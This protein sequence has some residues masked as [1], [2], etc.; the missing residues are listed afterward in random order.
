MC[1]ITGFWLNAA[2]A[3]DRARAALGDMS[4]SIAHRG[5]DDSDHYFDA[6]AGLGLAHRR[7]SIVDLSPEGRQPMVS[8]SGRYVIVF[9]GEV[10]N[11]RE[12]RAQLDANLVPL[13]FR[14][15]SD[16]E[17]M[18]AAIEAWGLD[19]A[20]A[21]FVGMFAFALWDRREHSLTLVRDRLGVKPLFY[22]PLARGFVFGSEL[23]AILAFPGF[24]RRLDDA[25]LYEFLLRGHVPAPRAIYEG[26]YK[27]P[28]G[29]TLRLSGPASPPVVERY[30]DAQQLGRAAVTQ[31]APPEESALLEEVD[32]LLRSAVR[33]RM[34]A[35]VPLGAFLSGGIDSSLVVALMQTQSTQPVRTFSIGSERA[36][37]DEG[38]AAARVAAHLG[39]AHTP[40][41]VTAADAQGVVPS[42][43]ALF[44]EPFADSSQIPTL[45]V[46]RLARAEVTVALTGDG[47]DES[48]GGYNRHSW[49]PRAWRVLR[50]LP[51]STRRRLSRGL[52]AIP[53]GGY[54]A[55]ARLVPSAIRPRLAGNKAHKL[56]GVMGSRSSA[57]LYRALCAHW[58]RP[59]DVLSRPVRAE[60]AF[61]TVD[62][63]DLA[64]D[65]M[66]LDTITYLPDDVLTKVDRATMAVA[67]EARSPLLDHRVV[68]LASRLPR[69]LKIRRGVGKWA[70]RE[71]LYRY[72]PRAL[73]DRPK[74][75]FAV[76]VG[77]WLRGPLKE[78]A[79]DLLLGDARRGAP[80]FQ[81]AAVRRTWEEHL[82]GRQDHTAKLWALLMFRAWLTGPHGTSQ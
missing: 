69:S 67:L 46:S 68:E 32:A 8:A 66:L 37:Y 65:M 12:L 21:R 60:S 58:L 56:L 40:F 64:Q 70:L 50:R 72:V 20:V 51:A 49:G 24:E 5:P 79:S 18:L 19:A 3:A 82:S 27:V 62:T 28:P 33:L 36:E 54:D 14:G 31:V 76:P 78:W 61:P 53:P 48:F 47:G 13:R 1:G 42:L 80:Y 2:W 4:T 52:G 17:V 6:A 16:T 15:E 45:L 77:A 81:P 10:Y 35:D 43:G 73:V 74:M 59:E 23:S 7:L 55:L 11:F 25:S 71:L 26:V 30:W 39:T 57:E 63:G 41:V 34:I 9:N 75:G 38:R 22:A 29:C 44:D